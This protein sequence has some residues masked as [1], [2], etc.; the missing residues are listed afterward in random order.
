MKIA[1]FSDIHNEFSEWKPNKQNVDVIVL[2]GDIHSKHHGINWVAEHFDVPVIY[3]P[4]NHEYY[5]CEISSNNK[6]MKSLAQNTNVYVLINDTVEID[7]V[8]FIGTTLWTNFLLYGIDNMAGCRYDA[9][10]YM[11]DFSRIRVNEKGRYRKL[12]PADTQLFFEKSLAFIVDS[13]AAKTQNK[14]VVVTHHAPSIKSISPKYNGDMLSAAF[15][16]NLDDF[17]N[18]WNIDLWLHGHTHHNTDYMIGNTRV[19]SNQRGY[20]DEDS[21]ELFNENIIVEI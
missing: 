10:N 9:E 1:V 19:V 16:S 7:G 2:A 11:N 6:K 18:E 5:G 4:G 20:P 3:V 21:N 15:T 8:L 12:K 17:I 14:C 13:L